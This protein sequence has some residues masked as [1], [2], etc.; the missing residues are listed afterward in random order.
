MVSQE[1]LDILVCPSCKGDL[2]YD[3]QKD[4]LTCYNRHCPTCGMPVN[5]SGTCQDSECGKT[6]T[7]FVALR[8]SVEDD[9]PIMLI[10][11]AE[12]LPL[13]SGE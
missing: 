7:S 3:D 8:Y 11:E 2:Q 13:S 1:L 10:Y 5:E 12:K 9:I 4:T 6:S